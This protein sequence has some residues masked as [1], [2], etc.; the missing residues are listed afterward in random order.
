MYAPF[1]DVFPA[2]SERPYFN[3]LVA[4]LAGQSGFEVFNL[5]TL[6]QLY[7]IESASMFRDDDHWNE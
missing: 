5:Q 6:M 2:L 4:E 1:F 3:D 7:A